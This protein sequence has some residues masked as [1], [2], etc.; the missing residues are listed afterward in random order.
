MVTKFLAFAIHC[1]EAKAIINY[2]EKRKKFRLYQSEGLKDVRRF[3]LPPSGKDNG[4]DNKETLLSGQLLTFINI[5][6]HECF[7][8][9]CNISLAV[10]NY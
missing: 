8:T 2:S 9:S 1:N 5:F 7:G 6:N 4:T 3:S 10:D